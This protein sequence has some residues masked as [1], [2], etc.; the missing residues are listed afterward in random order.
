MNDPK[1]QH[2]QAD[3]DHY[4]LTRAEQNL[5]VTLLRDVPDL[6]VELDIVISKQARLGGVG[7]KTTKAGLSELWPYSLH[8]SL[9]ANALHN[10]IV[11]WVRATCEQR[12]ITYAG[13]T[14]TTTLAQWLDRH[15]ISLAMT[16]G[17]GEALDD[18]GMQIDHARNIV[19]PPHRPIVVEQ[20]RV[21]EALRTPLNAHGIAAAAKELGEEYRNL[22]TRRVHHLRELQRI[23]PLVSLSKSWTP[24]WPARYELGRVL[25]AHLAVPIRNRNTRE[26]ATP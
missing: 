11:T 18:I 13:G 22:T 24:K 3:A 8:A 1:H 15:I 10:A 12:G 17:A 16:E 4:Y 14:S 7:G 23:K 21:E 6:I 19:Y 9:A 20:S 5:L 26:T 2:A 25:E